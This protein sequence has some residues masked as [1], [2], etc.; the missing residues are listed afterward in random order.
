MRAISIRAPWWWYILY[1]NKRV[2][3]RGRGFPR[4]TGP[5]LLHASKWWRNGEVV[6]TWDDVRAEGL[7]DGVPAASVKGWTWRRLRGAGGHIVGTADIVAVRPNRGEMAWEA[8]D[9][10]GLVLDNVKPLDNPVPWRGALGLFE[11]PWPQEA[12]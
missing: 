2:E 6:E 7:L 1:A 12:V 3:N 5:V 8:P 10:L 9:Q 4:Y 11:V